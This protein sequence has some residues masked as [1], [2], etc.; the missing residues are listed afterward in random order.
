MRI[1]ESLR[2][3]R[4]NTRTAVVF[5]PLW[6]VPFALFSFYLSLYMKGLGVTDHQIGFLISLGSVAGAV[7][8]FVGGPVTDRLGRKR[9]TLIFDFIA[10][11]VAL[12]L[13]IF[14][15]NF[16]LFALAMVI[17][18]CWR[19]VSVSW[20]LMV[21]EDADNEQR[22]AAFNLLNIVSV[23][24]GI[25][26][27]LAGLLVRSV[28]VV[29]AE[30]VLLGFGV[31]SIG[32]Q[33][34]VRNHYFTETSVGR[35]ILRR[36]RE[37]RARGQRGPGFWT[38]Y[39]EAFAAMRRP[40]VRRTVALVVL[41]LLL[42]PVGSFSSL[43]FAPYLT[44]TLK[45]GQAAI[46]LLGGLYSAV[47]LVVLTFVVPRLAG[48]EEGAGREEGARRGARH[49]PRDRAS[50]GRGAGG[51]AGGGAEPPSPADRTVE[52]LVGLGAQ[53]AALVLFAVVPPGSF[54]LTAG[55][56]ALYAVG[57]SIFRPFLDAALA[58]VT[59]GVN[60]AGIYAISNALVSLLGSAAAAFSGYLFQLRPAA[61]WLAAAGVLVACAGL[62]LALRW[63]PAEE[64]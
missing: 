60:R 24:T 13:Y 56:V 17:N 20:N 33:V 46:S 23:A 42:V 43:Y 55:V 51:A 38:T 28:G 9:T 44:E 63:A 15:S 21:V 47:L 7:S 34:L 14:A 30:R 50:V 31:V 26:T 62:V 6:G 59:E 16:W 12:T 48:P 39:R 25:L 2:L 53:A 4:G 35:E 32:T 8:S 57:F 40:R 54:G 41:Y 61:V 29:T 18:N 58:A 10:W 1:L 49:R 52:M 3:L 64:D 5:E 45:L 27:P 36:R 19:I 11:P 37:A 22:V